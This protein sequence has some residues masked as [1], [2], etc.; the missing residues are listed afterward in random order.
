MRVRSL[1]HLAVFLLSFFSGTA[2]FA[3]CS[4]PANAIVAENCKQGNPSTEWDIANSTAGD[5]NIQGFATDISVDSGQT[6]HFKI[7]TSASAYQINIYR[8]G[9]YGG[10]GARKI[11]SVTPSAHLPQTQPA[12]LTDAATKLVDCGNWVESASW[13]V[14]SD[15][16]SGLYIA[17]LIR[18]DTG[19]DSHIAFVVRND[20]S[21]SD[22]LV[23]T[24]DETWQAY[25]D[26][27]GNSLY[28]PAG[29]FDPSNRAFKVSYN[30]PFHTR[31]FELASWLFYSEYPMIKFLE[32]NGYDLTYFAS[33]DA[34]RSGNLINN[35]KI[36]LSVGHDEYASGPKMTN[37]L[38]ARDAGVNLAFFSGNEFFWKTR[39][40]NSIDGSNTAFRTLVCYKE[41][42]N[43]GRTDPQDPSTWTGTW[44]DPRFSPPADGGRPE[45]LLTGT[46]FRVNGYNGIDNNALSIQI[47]AADGKMR[48]WRNTSVASQQ[49]GQV[50]TLPGGTLGYEWDV[51]DIGGLRPAGVVRLSTA[52]YPL[53]TD[54]LLDYGG[55]YGAGNATHHLT[56]YRA[57]SGALVFGAGTLQWSWGLDADHD[58]QWY[59]GFPA[60]ANMQQA[61]VNL[62]AD[63]GAQPA[64]LISAL[65]P[66]TKSTDTTAPQSAITSPSPGTVVQAGTIT[67]VSGTAK[68]F[69][70]GIIGGVEVSA[71]GGKTWRPANGRESWTYAW[72]PT[73]AGPVTLI[74][75]AVDDSG[76]IETPSTS[77]AVS[78]AAPDCPCTIFGAGTPNLIDSG[79]VNSGEFGIRFQADYD[80][81]ITGLRFYKSAKNTGTHVGHLW[82]NSGVLLAGATFT[83]ES[84]TG[85][86]QVSFSNPVPI[87][88][89][90]TYVVSYFTPT[91]HYSSDSGAFITSVDN[92]PLHAPQDGISGLS[93]VF[94]Y[95]SAGRFPTSTFGSANYWVD[96]IYLPGGSLPGAPPSL[97]ATPGSLSFAAYSNEPAPAAQNV[98]IHDQ[99]SA[100]L[101]WT[102]SANAPWIVLSATS[103]STPST[104]AVGVNQ[105]GLAA[106][107]YNGTVTISSS[108]GTQT[109]S[110][111]LTVAALVASENFSNVGIEGW[112]PSSIGTLAGWSVTGGN[113]RYNGSGLNQL[114]AGDSSWTDYTF[115]IQVQ[116]DTLNNYPGGIRGRVNP[117]TGAGY[118]VWLYPGNSNVRLFKAT[119]WDINQGLTELSGSP[120]TA[121][122]TAGGFHTLA[123]S[124]HGAQIQVL[125]DGNVVITATDSTYSSGLVALDGFNQPIS[126]NNLL[127]TAP[128]SNP[129]NIIT[130]SA[131]LNFSGN[132]Q[133]PNPGPQS[134][135][136]TESGTGAIAFSATTTASWLTVSPSFTTTPAAM[137]VSVN[138]SQLSAGTYN[139][140][141]LLTS[142]GAGNN[143]ASIAVTLNVV[144]PPPAISL[145][146]AGMNFLALTG[147]PAPPAQSLSISNAG[148]G[149]FSW[150]ASSDSSWLTASAPSGST[151]ST[152]SISVNQAGLA[153]GSYSGNVTV[154]ASG[155]GNSP[156]KVPVTLTVLSQGLAENFSDL[157]HG[158]IISPLGLGNGWS[159]ANGV[160]SFN[161]S[162]LSQSC[163]G[164]SSWSDYIFD[165][166]IQLTNLNNWPGGVRARVNPSTGAGYVVWLY[167]G[168]GRMKLYSVDQWNINS[169]NLALLAQANLTFDLNLHDLQMNFHGNQITVSWD[170]AVLISATDSTYNSGFVCMDAD[171][172]PI[173]YSNIR[174]ASVQSPVTIDPAAGSLSFVTGP[175]APA[176]AQ[177]VNITASGAS[178]TWAVTSNASW[179]QVSPSTALTPGK[180][181]VSVNSTGLAQGTYSGTV[182]VYVPGAT[183]SPIT[184]PV[185]FLVDTK[186]LAVSPGSFSFFGASGNP[187]P[188]RK[189]N[190]TNSGTGTLS[191]TATANASWITMSAASGTAP[192]AINVSPNLSGLANGLYNG[193]I[194]IDG[195][196]AFNSPA[197]VPV[198]LQVGALAFSDNFSAG[199]GNWTISPLGNAAGWSVANSTYSFNGQGPSQA[200]AG[201]PSWTDY[202]FSLDY[203]L[204]SLNN[205]PGGIRGRVNPATGAGYAAWIYPAT[206]L[207]RLWRLGQWNIDTDSTLTLLGQ[208]TPIAIDLNPH[209][210]TL[211]FRGTQISVY[212]D[213]TL[214][215]QAN[216]STYTQGVVA[217][218]TYNQP[219]S[220]SNVNVFSF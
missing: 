49:A 199:A 92:P 133:G 114:Y 88:A 123:L 27:G 19:G 216:D 104:L 13:A 12:C 58:R 186:G 119:G 105:S 214:V 52:T 50:W 120:G 98:S 170:G 64:T 167:P 164:N 178:T 152:V 69:G 195:G 103:G 68:D 150:T 23:Q 28:G 99:G 176:P 62:F 71:D 22:L 40:E 1:T 7:N 86:Q 136:V 44:R 191:W 77:V 126:Y 45:N 215:I 67:T 2:A 149:S 32:A 87:T 200:Y 196:D 201:N 39:W 211:S 217:L 146:P 175:G 90:T 5:P 148:V 122:I 109:I 20:A 79:D 179:L 101:G 138:T 157:A 41:T 115:Q 142:V 3:D 132:F 33:V 56:L 108:A 129:S 55:V 24:S 6:I 125:F 9:Y 171:S 18:S 169:P 48:F 159:V 183:N 213:N 14:P 42:L 84:A 192:S 166:N 118:L 127:I 29:E 137:Q 194:T 66:A 154:S 75:R 128:V 82:T 135:Q 37:I 46:I 153:L 83:S 197:T 93:G 209:N 63:M 210:V 38:S 11:V 205:Y 106:G 51:D 15:A 74:S 187:V 189:L 61:T 130:G 113:L 17:H 4:A 160:Y 155:V 70:G 59:P 163:A 96:V 177:T 198:S 124:F 218:E 26:F 25:N 207:L 193:S 156:Q 31:G 34:A 94:S 204:S 43:N 185:T 212:L 36:Y 107:A 220:F 57:S 173:S 180:I 168:T 21:H 206:G 190:I 35:H 80:G 81:F 134:V 54:Y 188:A 208:P 121:G 117:Q 147:Q 144:I 78:V 141:V 116:V 102:A 53:I 30:R 182:M 100:V 95:A 161:G 47:P 91:G 151:P 158:W 10:L 76:N 184:I 89:N 73:I 174:V 110:V 112:V 85:W 72:S 162:G 165:T 202:A 181:T 8:L 131:S 65:L 203:Q 111:N 140:Q 97:L 219:V 143:P 145:S 172:Q 139:A 16:V 60:D